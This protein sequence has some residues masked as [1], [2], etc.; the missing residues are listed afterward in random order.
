MKFRDTVKM[1]TLPNGLTVITDEVPNAVTAFMSV[2]LMT[3]SHHDPSD[4]LG[5][6]H[7]SEHLDSNGHP[8][9]DRDALFAKAADEAITS[10]MTTGAFYTDYFA[11]GLLEDVFPF[12]DIVAECLYK[13]AYTVGQFEH[14]YDRINNEV[15]A[16]AQAESQQKAN[17]FSRS[18]FG[19]NI[20]ARWQGGTPQGFANITLH[21]IAK[22]HEQTHVAKNMFVCASGNLSHEQTMVWAD[23]HFSDLKADERSP[24][25]KSDLNPTDIWVQQENASETELTIS[26]P[27]PLRNNNNRGGTSVISNMFQTLLAP[28]IIREFGIY[29]FGVGMGSQAMGQPFFVMQTSCEP[30]R[31]AL[32][33]VRALELVESLLTSDID[34]TRYQA[35]ILKNLDTGRIKNIYNHEQRHATI[36]DDFLRCANPYDDDVYYEQISSADFEEG[37]R[38]I[39]NAIQQKPATF[40]YGNIT[41]DLPAGDKIERRDFSGRSKRSVQLT[42]FDFTPFR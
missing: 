20:E 11:G 41:D 9:Y 3:G 17:F 33:I 4:K 7:I 8:N 18:H 28:I 12:M 39:L 2:N 42:R 21:D 23:R 1:S 5:L 37:K 15:R 24:I 19:D 32:I 10:N 34:Y 6:A 31:A 22:Y 40:Y 27:V 25:I 35:R 13:R 30:N 29:G 38:V 14:E 36:R 16:Y 26:F